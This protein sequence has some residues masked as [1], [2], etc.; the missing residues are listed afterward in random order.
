MAASHFKLLLSI[1]VAGI[2]MVTIRQVHLNLSDNGFDRVSDTI[3]TERAEEII[4]LLHFD[5]NRIGLG[6]EGETAIIEATSNRLV[7]KADLDVDGNVET[8]RYYLSDAAAATSTQNP[9]DKILYRVVDNEPEV[10]VPMGVTEFELKY[11]N[12]PEGKETTDLDE[13][14]T[15]EVALVVQ[16]TISTDDEYTNYARRLRSSPPNLI[17]N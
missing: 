12:A 15:I 3:S 16:N 7:F 8:V 10:D 4:K 2:M 1:F 14:R 13:I 17:F 5:L 9:H 11:F 6:V